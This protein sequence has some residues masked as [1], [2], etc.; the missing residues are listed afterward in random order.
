MFAPNKMQGFVS[1]KSAGFAVSNPGNNPDPLPTNLHNGERQTP[2]IRHH[3]MNR[4]I[5]IRGMAHENLS[6]TSLVVSLTLGLCARVLAAV[7]S[8]RGRVGSSAKRGT[9]R[10]CRPRQ[11]T[12]CRSRLSI[13]S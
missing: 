6:A 13:P 3:K 7:D 2:G 10:L 9:D 1:F 8:V 11:R 5:R 12:A 4:Q